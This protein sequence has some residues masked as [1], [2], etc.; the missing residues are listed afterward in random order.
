MTIPDY[1]SLMLPVMRL[2]ESSGR[3]RVRDMLDELCQQFGL[4]EYERE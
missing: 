3:T 4:S 1:Q 2:V